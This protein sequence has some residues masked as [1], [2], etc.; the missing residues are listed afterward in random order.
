MH[1]SVALSLLL[2]ALTGCSRNSAPVITI[3]TAAQISEFTRHASITLPASAQAIGW[4]EERG[5][6]DA[7][8]LQVR[9]P[10]QDWQRF[11]DS[12]PFRNATL[13][14]NDQYRVSEFKEFFAA[15]PAR[16][17]AG[18]QQLP[19]ARVLNMVVDESD[20]TNVLVYLI[21]HET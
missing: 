14:T 3:P 21:W 12:S 5:T 7:L 19:N 4:R 15:P 6:D 16:Y 13:A 8:W 9:M 11:L 10:A 1:T 18:Q 17:R 2:A 20:T